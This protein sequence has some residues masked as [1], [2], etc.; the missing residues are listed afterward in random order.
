MGVHRLPY[1]SSPPPLASGDVHVWLA[2]LTP[3]PAGVAEHLSE[4]E[5]GRAAGYKLAVVRDQF[6]AGRGVLRAILGGYCATDPGALDVDV[7]P[8]GKPRL[9]SPAGWHFNVSHS[10]GM[11]LVAVSDTPVGVDLEPVRPIENA[12]GLVE[13]FFA[14][15]EKSAYRALSAAAKPAGFLRGWTCKEAVLKAIGIG[16]RRME[17]CAVEMDPAKPA[18]VV[19]I[20]NCPDDGWAVETWTPC[21]G[22]L[23]AVAYR[24]EK[25]RGR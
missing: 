9:R 12:D 2:R 25:G 20:G 4:D 23:A 18:R 11:G 14:T 13:R 16:M 24:N 19:R 1:P 10:L 5:R 21:E 6:V 3:C 8:L 17:E 22:F 15:E 7:D